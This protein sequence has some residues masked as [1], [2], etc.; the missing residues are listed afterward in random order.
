MNSLSLLTDGAE[1]LWD[2]TI[3]VFQRSDHMALSAIFSIVMKK[4]HQ[5]KFLITFYYSTSKY[6]CS[7]WSIIKFRFAHVGVTPCYKDSQFIFF[8]IITYYIETCDYSWL[9]GRFIT[10]KMEQLTDVGV[11]YASSFSVFLIM[12]MAAL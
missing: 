12:M 5:I 4:K 10:I 11:N 1:T 6:A 2:F 8:V 9:Y 7:N 3:R